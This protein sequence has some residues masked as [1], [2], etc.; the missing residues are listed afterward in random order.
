M[1]PGVSCPRGLE[2]A[3][4]QR[5]I[6]VSSVLLLTACPPFWDVIRV[7]ENGG[8]V[9]MRDSEASYSIVRGDGTIDLKLV[10]NGTTTTFHFD[11]HTMSIK[12]EHPGDFLLF[13]CSD[14]H[15]A[16]LAE[17]LANN[18]AFK[19]RGRGLKTYPWRS[20]PITA[21]Q[22]VLDHEATIDGK[23][24]PIAD[25]LAGAAVTTSTNEGPP[26]I[27]TTARGEG[28]DRPDGGGPPVSHDNP[29]ECSG[30]VVRKFKAAV[31][32]GSLDLFSTV[33]LKGAIAK[34]DGSSSCFTVP[35]PCVGTPTAGATG[36]ITA[37]GDPTNPATNNGYKCKKFDSTSLITKA[38]Q[39]KFCNPGPVHAV[40]V[41]LSLQVASAAS[42]Q[43]N[44]PISEADMV[45]N[46]SAEIGYISGGGCDKSGK[47]HGW[48]SGFTMKAC[49]DGSCSAS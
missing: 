29:A 8:K 12:G 41:E 21:A 45:S 23:L 44:G 4:V 32:E 18:A 25:M 27:G 42:L 6:F 38:V 33:V 10:A 22:A 20:F 28:E 24:K 35:P 15:C 34:V 19:N 36:T 47:A 31:F 13:A 49:I 16:D 48:L 14:V 37:V 30:T 43:L 40:S 7:D 26:K 39:G 17:T 46:A 11:D 1:A 5:L 2:M 9:R 3:K